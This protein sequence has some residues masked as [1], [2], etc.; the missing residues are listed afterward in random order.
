M[1]NTVWF[2]M[3]FIGILYG[4]FTGNLGELNNIILKEAQEGVTFAISLIGIMCFWL[5]MMNIAEKSGLIKSISRGFRPIVR[6]LFPD[7]PKDHPAERWVLMNFIANMFGVGNGATAFGLKA[8]KELDS[9][10]PN[11]KKA[12]NAM[13][14]FLIINMSSLQLVPL[15]VVKLRYDYGSKNP[16]GIIGITILATFLST[17]V[18]IIVGKIFEGGKKC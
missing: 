4:A 2:L 14:M 10:N 5:G 1:I 8:M 11:K 7:I 17:I 16:T 15:T 9:L 3:I 13:A 18:A 6:L 12:T